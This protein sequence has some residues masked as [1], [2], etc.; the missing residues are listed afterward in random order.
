MK[1]VMILQAFGIGDCIWS[2]GIANHFI[3]KGY[4][5]VWP[6]KTHFVDGLQRAYPNVTWIPDT[7]V[8]P[9]IFDIKEMIV[10]D[11]MLI[12]PI[13]WSDSYMKVPYA[14]VM[15]AK[16]DMYELD[17]RMWKDHALWR[18][19]LDKGVSLLAHL[20]IKYGEK[21]NLINKRFGTNAERS[22][23]ISVS[24][25]Y[26]NIE[27]TNIEGYSLFDWMMVMTSAVEIHTVST[28]IIY[29]LELLPLAK[30]IHLYVR[31]PIEQDFSFVSFMF[32]KPYIFHK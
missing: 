17:W 13:R 5:V 21:F 4:N 18:N 24:N 8:K 31:K 2:Q 20:G 1:T 11:G 16:Y 19:D 26:R 23:E 15:K 9:E 12:A 10:V 30:P 32:T 14:Y 28:S 29:M 27:M 6:V 3:E 25:E 22:V 7:V